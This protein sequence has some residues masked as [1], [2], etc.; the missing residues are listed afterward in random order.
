MPQLRAWFVRFGGLFRKRRNEAQM[1]AEMRE[2]IEQ[3]TERKI[4]NGMSP[5]EARN[6]ALREFGGTE[7]IKE[8]AREQRVWR[9]A[10]DF[11]QDLRFGARMLGRNPGFSALAILCLTVGIG[12][13]AVV[14]SWI[15]GMLFRPY[16]AVAHQERMFALS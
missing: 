7:Q 6:A 16:P 4:A 12:S 8:L 15:E 1:A 5:N 13:N 2:H 10:D 9:A 14:F 3:L 11:I